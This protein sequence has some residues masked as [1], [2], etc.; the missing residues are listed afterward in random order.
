[1]HGRTSQEFRVKVRKSAARQRSD[2]VPSHKVQKKKKKKR[3]TIASEVVKSPP[4]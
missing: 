4:L 2:A 3:K 1:M